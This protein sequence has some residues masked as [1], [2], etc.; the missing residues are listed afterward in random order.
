[1]IKPND[2]LIFFLINDDIEDVPEFKSQKDIDDFFGEPVSFTLRDYLLNEESFWKYLETWKSSHKFKIVEE[3]ERCY[4]R[5]RGTIEVTVI[6]TLDDK[7][8]SISYNS[9]LSLD[10]EI[11]S[12]SKEVIP[13]EEK[14]IKYVEKR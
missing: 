6:Y 10:D 8:Y 14:V 3:S 12:S 13:V 11:S 4:D 9:Y 1:M 5:Y 7:Y 2:N